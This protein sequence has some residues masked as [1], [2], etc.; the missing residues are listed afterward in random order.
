M[1]EIG[2]NS[3]NTDRKQTLGAY[4]DLNNIYNSLRTF[5]T[6]L[7][8]AGASDTGAASKYYQNLLSGP[9]SSLTAA[10]SPE[11]NALTSQAG[12]TKRELGTSPGNRTGGTNAAILGT[13]AG[14]R[15]AIADT[16]AKE[17]AG[18][19]GSLAKIGG[20][21]TGQAITST[22]DAG[23]VKQGVLDS[24]IKS[25]QLSQNIHDQ[26]VSDWGNAIASVLLA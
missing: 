21:E 19:A 20:Q 17:R 3:A 12:E 1:C 25:R 15:G 26:A 4:G 7:S 5:G 22:A 8:T 24:S 23:S 2:G 14:T 13:S 18:A 10:A 16:L 11:I 9:P 6:R